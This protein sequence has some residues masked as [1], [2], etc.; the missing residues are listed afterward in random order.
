MLATSLD[1]LQQNCYSPELT[2]R[3]KGCFWIEDDGEVDDFVCLSSGC[4]DGGDRLEVG[5]ESFEDKAFCSNCGCEGMLDLGAPG[6]NSGKDGD[7]RWAGLK[8][9]SLVDERVFW[10][11]C[12]DC[13]WWWV[14]DLLLLDLSDDGDL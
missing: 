14:V 1:L 5:L 12:T 7:L 3:S 4:K 8:Q 10:N 2:I 11:I 6:R 9:D 13:C